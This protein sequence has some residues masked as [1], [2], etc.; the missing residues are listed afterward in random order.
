MVGSGC[1]VR[2]TWGLLSPLLVLEVRSWQSLSALRLSHFALEAGVLAL[3]GCWKY[4]RRIILILRE[5]TQRRCSSTVAT[6]VGRLYVVPIGLCIRRRSWH[7]AVRRV[8]VRSRMP[9]LSCE[10]SLSCW[11]VIAHSRHIWLSRI[12]WLVRIWLVVALLVVSRC[13]IRRLTARRRMCCCE[14][15]A[16]HWI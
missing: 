6:T 11:C 5:G 7:V 15:L 10:A 2:R 9:T 4:S 8:V 13:T 3:P 14:R 16:M 12:A 1:C